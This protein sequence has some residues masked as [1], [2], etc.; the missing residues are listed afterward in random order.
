MSI[1][2]VK[3]GAILKKNLPPVN[4]QNEYSLRYRISSDIGDRK[5]HWSPIYR[6]P[7][8]P[9]VEVDGSIL[10][11]TGGITAVW[12]DEADRPAYDI[13]VRFSTGSYYYHGTSPIHTYS[14][15]ISGTD[16][17]QVAVQVEGIVKER[18]NLLEIYESPVISL[19]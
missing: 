12:G 11:S 10:L 2:G 17:V 15:L 1:P 8:N 4:S 18:N 19:V 7:G 6:I 16:S 5:S 14:F 3:K 9:V 13:F